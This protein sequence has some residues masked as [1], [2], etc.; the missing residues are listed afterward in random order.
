MTT[1]VTEWLVTQDVAFSYK[2][3][4]KLL[5]GKYVSRGGAMCESSEVKCGLF[6][7]GLVR[8]NPKIITGN[9][10]SDGRPCVHKKLKS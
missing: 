6:L 8:R 3:I 10:F 7:L 5:S 2:G 4:E 9:L 1:V